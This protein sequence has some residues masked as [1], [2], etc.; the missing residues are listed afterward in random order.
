M[1]N[2]DDTR[3]H[4]ISVNVGVNAA[5]ELAKSSPDPAATFVDIVDNVV[6]VVLDV[7]TKNQPTAAVNPVDAVR[8]AF[9]GATVVN[10][11]QPQPQP[12]TVTTEAGGFLASQG[13][14]PA[15]LST[16]RDNKPQEQAIINEL[17]QVPSNFYDNR[18]D[19]RNPK[20]PD[21]KRKSD[22]APLWIR[23]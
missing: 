17:D 10:Q 14:N 23:G 21:F 20:A 16:A 13:L 9:P 4:N 15:S 2:Y 5:V 6:K 22:G 11:P 3:N 12:T 18:Q 8:G 19:K 7:H 1:S